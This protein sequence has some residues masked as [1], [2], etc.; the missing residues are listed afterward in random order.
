MATQ[1]EINSENQ[2]LFDTFK[3]AMDQPLEGTA[4]TLQAAGF[5][6]SEE[7]VRNLIESPE[8]YVSY[9]EKFINAQDKEHWADYEWKHF[10]GFVAE[11]AGQ[12]AGSIASRV[13]AMG[14]VGA[15]TKN[16]YAAVAAG[17][18][19]PALFEAVQVAGP[20]ALQ[21][22]EERTGKKGEAPN[23]KDWGFALAASATSGLLNSLGVLGVMKPLGKSNIMKPLAGA[24]AE[25]TTEGLQALNEQLF[26]T[27]GSPKG[28]RIDTHQAM[29]EALAGGGTG[30]VASTVPAVADAVA[31]M[32]GSALPGDAPI[33]TEEAITTMDEVID[34]PSLLEETPQPQDEIAPIRVQ[35]EQEFIDTESTTPSQTPTEFLDRNKDLIDSLIREQLNLPG[36]DNLPVATAFA[37]LNAML[38]EDVGRHWDIYGLHNEIEHPRLRPPREAAEATLDVL[39]QTLSNYAGRLRAV[40]QVQEGQNEIDTRFEEE[41]IQPFASSARPP[42]DKSSEFLTRSPLDAVLSHPDTPLGKAAD[43]AELQANWLMDKLNVKQQ[44]NKEGKVTKAFLPKGKDTV[45]GQLAIDSG[46]A[47][48]LRHRKAT[49]E[50][51]N[52]NEIRNLLDQHEQRFTSSFVTGSEMRHDGD[53][54]R[55]PDSTVNLDAPSV[56]FGSYELPVKFLP[57]GGL[58]KFGR[59]E[60]DDSTHGWYSDDEGDQLFW[61]RGEI[62]EDDVDGGY[63]LMPLELQSEIYQNLADTTFVSQM[64]EVTDPLFIRNEEWKRIEY[65]AYGDHSSFLRNENTLSPSEDVLAAYI[66][67]VPYANATESEIM[68]DIN[69]GHL[70]INDWYNLANYAEEKIPSFK[71]FRAEQVR[72]GDNKTLDNFKDNLLKE[73][74]YAI[75]YGIELTRPLLDKILTPKGMKS[76]PI[77]DLEAYIYDQ[78]GDVVHRRLPEV[79]DIYSRSAT[80][81]EVENLS[82]TR[83][84]LIELLPEIAEV[85]A[86]QHNAPHFK[87]IWEARYLPLSREERIKLHDSQETLRR[88]EVEPDYPMKTTWPRYA[89]LN[90]IRHMLEEGN[91]HYLYMPSEGFGQRG[92]QGPY[93]K[94]QDQMRK[95][96]KEFDLPLKEIEIKEEGLARHPNPNILRLDIR[97]LHENPIDVE[98]KGMKSGG[99]VMNYGDYGRSYK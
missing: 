67:L 40:N 7:F 91:M 5:K 9:A 92:P 57:A 29:A 78:T 11:Q 4:A 20:V 50:T 75:E 44:R 48:L 34:Q 35:T 66:R 59:T 72:E 39:N 60:R 8:N 64:D 55:I 63:G 32:Q 95:L 19:G 70:H 47:N 36:N 37:D 58:D 17:I 33:T 85:M 14:A 56:A 10:P 3:Y 18:A 26:S 49:G 86:D 77:T 43:D 12:L 30:G 51:V 45:V 53:Y 2:S 99:L 93:I 73:Q 74:P 22:A 13:G 42:L 23:A 52:K 94:A 69:D 98:F 62:V 79:Q 24:G 71:E 83:K 21:R 28:T 6:E 38:E 88:G 1:P 46:V 41:L 82:K 25:F 80:N 65:E 31:Q 81:V 15:L 68:A 89:V 87:D 84:K 16:P 54:Y 27:I 97:K 76:G 61:S 96:A 90:H